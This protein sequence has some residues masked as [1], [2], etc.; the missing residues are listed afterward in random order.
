MEMSVTFPAAILAPTRHAD[1]VKS[2]P[3]ATASRPRVTS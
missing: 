1:A 2:Q 3:A